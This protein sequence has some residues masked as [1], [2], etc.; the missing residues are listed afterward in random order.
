[1]ATQAA[2]AMVL[3][4]GVPALLGRTDLGLLASAGA[5]TALYLAARAR[6]ERAGRLPIVQAGFLAAA[7]V[8]AATG[9]SPFAP[10]VLAL[11]TV[12]ASVLVL[13][14][15]IGPPG[16]VFVVLVAGV[17]GR[18]TAPVT[19]G[20][21]G[22]DP[23]LVIG[24]EAVG[25]A[26][27]YAIAVLPLLVPSVR[28]RDAALPVASVRFRIDA[29][30]RIV[31]IR[32]A[33]GAGIA[34]GLGAMLGLHRAYWVLLAVVAALQAGHGRR[35]TALRGVHRALGTL[36]GAAAFALLALVP[37]PGVVLALVVGALQFVTELV[38]VRHY[39]LALVFITPLALT[40]AEA[41]SPGPVPAL[42]L[43]RIVDTAVGAAV[44]LL[45]LVVD[46]AVERLAAR[47]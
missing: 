18:L 26:L 6:R 44:A 37:L 9:G 45:V 42:I 47:H 5:L 7:V 1:V 39:G 35:M 8:G 2:L 4:V 28:R 11:L 21:V 10:L 13:G 27:A 36:V 41:G 24:M 15:S 16:A 3:A 33:V 14:F 32:I 38:V 46:L 17:T 22:L 25:C 23:R 40:V 34:A 31:L 43:D 12:A 29:A 30:T 19:S 20:G